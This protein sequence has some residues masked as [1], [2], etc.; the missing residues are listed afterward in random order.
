MQS[1]TFRW[2]GLA[3]VGVIVL[4]AAGCRLDTNRRY[5]VEMTTGDR[6]VKATSDKIASI[7]FDN[8]SFVI[9]FSAKKCIVERE[10]ILYDGKE[11]A[12]IPAEATSIVIEFIDGD[13]MVVADGQK[14]RAAS[15]PQ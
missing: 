11:Q 1:R 6:T 8:R 14:V 5:T 2:T 13:F 7:T 12:R 3:T 15:P 9:S 4:A 10:R